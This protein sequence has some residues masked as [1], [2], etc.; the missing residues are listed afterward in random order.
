MLLIE[1]LIH[2]LLDNGALTKS[3]ALEVIASASQVKEES[4]AEEKEPAQTLK[5][6]LSLLV[7]MRQSIEAHSGRYNPEDRSGRQKG[8]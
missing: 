8:R 6:S 3:Q 5:K 7:S 4:A 1:S 2:S